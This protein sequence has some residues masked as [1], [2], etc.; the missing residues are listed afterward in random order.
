MMRYLL[1]QA[2][3]LT[4]QAEPSV[5]SGLVILSLVILIWVLLLRRLNQPYFIAYILSGV[6]LGPDGLRVLTNPELIIQLG[7]LGIILLLFFIGLEIR[8]PDLTKQVR[9]PLLGMLFQVALSGLAAWMVGAYMDWSVPVMLLVAF[10]LSL[11]SSAIIHPYLAQHNETNT[12]LGTLTTGVLLLQD[13]ATIPMLLTLNFLGKGQFNAV[14]LTLM[15]VG[16]VLSLLFLQ[17]AMRSRLIQLPFADAL[18]HDHDL[19]VFVGLVICFGMAWLT[20][21]FH[22][23]AALGAFLAG[24][25]VN[26]SSATRWLEHSLLPFRVFFLALFFVAVGLQI[27]IDFFL[28]NWL[29]VSILVLLV[30][31]INSLLGTL[32]F[33]AA[34]SS[35]RDSVYAGA[36]LSQLGEFSIVLGLTARQLGLINEFIYQLTLSV[37]ALTMLITTLWIEVIRRFLFRPV[38]ADSESAK[39]QISQ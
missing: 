3:P 6:V 25:L 24:V 15:V 29:L 27:K 23:S 13:M 11:S 32:A 8:L 28:A 38:P 9:K 22:L 31:I 39:H 7:E 4:I 33:R 19:Q 10:V 30:L 16:G 26:R 36:L 12:P 1:A 37:V 21:A 34:G 35:W 18:L 2:H 17:M 5:L 14:E 20:Q